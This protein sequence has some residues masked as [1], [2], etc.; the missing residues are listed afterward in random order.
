MQ[1]FLERKDFLEMEYFYFYSPF[2]CYFSGVFD[3]NQIQILSFQ[4]P[5]FRLG[6]SE[7][8]AAILA[9]CSSCDW[10]PWVAE[11][12]FRQWSWFFSHSHHCNLLASVKLLLIHSVVK[13]EL[14]LLFHMFFNLHDIFV[15]TCIIDFLGIYPAAGRET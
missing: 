2:P 5:L 12:I 1:I 8:N 10:T 9:A 6:L 4:S 3:L 14:C 13:E 7:L 11:V 15:F